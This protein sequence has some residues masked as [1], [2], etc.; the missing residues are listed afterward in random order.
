MVQELCACPEALSGPGLFTA[1]AVPLYPR[2]LYPA[3]KGDVTSVH[4]SE[5]WCGLVVASLWEVA[6]VARRVT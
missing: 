1:E 6:G 3:D 5:G 4:P 2:P